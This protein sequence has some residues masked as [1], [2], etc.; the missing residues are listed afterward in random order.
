MEIG[1]FSKSDKTGYYFV[2]QYGFMLRKGENNNGEGDAIGRSMRSF[3]VYGD[4]CFIDAIIN[5]WMFKLGPR[6]IIGKRHPLNDHPMSRDHFINTMVAYEFGSRRD[7][8]LIM[9]RYSRGRISDMA[10]FTPSMWYWVQYLGM[11]KK[12]SLRKYYTFEI[13]SMLGYYPMH[14]VGKLFFKPEVD[15][16]NWKPV[17]IQHRSKFVQTIENWMPQAF[18][19]QQAGWM[20]YILP[21]TRTNRFVKWLYRGLV[22]NTNYVNKMLHGGKVEEFDVLN[23][24]T[25]RGGRW[26]G[27]LSGRNDR[28]LDMI[29]ESYS[30]N[31]DKDLLIKLYKLNN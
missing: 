20:L 28:V 3:F 6:R 2:D 14:W 8:Q 5:S 21:N 9:A 13:L 11:R 17:Y 18:F 29:P 27:W 1:R 23:Y 30:N 12:S 25:M 10:C 31:L 24:K 15:Q 16:V 26:S 22:G 19:I 4:S 7:Q